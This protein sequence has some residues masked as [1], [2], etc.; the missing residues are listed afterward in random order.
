M[1]GTSARALARF[2]GLA[3][4]ARLVIAHQDDVGMCHGANVAFARLAGRGFITC[5]SVM[6]PCPWFREVVAIAE[7]DP[8]LDIG[9]HLTLTAEW[10]HYRWRP[11]STSS[12]ASGL[13]D[14]DGFMWR[15]V[16]MLR[17]HVVA[18]AAEAE[19]RAQIDAA[20]AA[21]LAITHLDTHMG[22]AL[23]PELIDVYMRLGRDYGLP[24]LF[25]RGASGYIEVLNMGE[26]DATIYDQRVATIE[27]AGNPV[28]DHVALTPGAPSSESDKAYRELVSAVPAGLSFL[29]FHC[30]APGDIE[31]I[32]PP[33]AHWRTDE[34][35]I[36]QDPDFLDWTAGTGIHLIG[37]RDILEFMR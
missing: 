1:T 34:F 10:E 5:G 11:L 25:P 15:R 7:A 27:A 21:G 23:T 4:G 32:V 36:F 37:F 16:P 8:T 3:D 35:R 13:I 12:K 22:A 2:L 14:D 30:C 6:V 17:D 24:I 9:V 28:V 19:M 29:A 31:A 18:E 33:R 26:V 20:V